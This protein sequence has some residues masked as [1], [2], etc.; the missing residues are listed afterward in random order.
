MSRVP[1]RPAARIAENCIGKPPIDDVVRTVGCSR[2]NR[3]DRA[4]ST[5]DAETPFPPA[6]LNHIDLARPGLS[7][8]L[9][10]QRQ[11]CLAR[12]CRQAIRLARGEGGPNWSLGFT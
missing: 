4:I 12:S 2:R 8:R 9:A 10:G 11:A 6:L 3:E 1:G 5:S 7:G